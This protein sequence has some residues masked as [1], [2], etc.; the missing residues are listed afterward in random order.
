M[1]WYFALLPTLIIVF[2]SSILIR[3]VKNILNESTDTQFV[4]VVNIHDFR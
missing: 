4:E 2:S 1:S 3:I